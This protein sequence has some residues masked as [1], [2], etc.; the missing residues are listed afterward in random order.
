MI[1]CIGDSHASFFSGKDQMQPVW[2]E[3]N[4]GIY[5]QFQAYRLGAVLAYNL[6]KANST[7]GGRELLLAV[8]DTI[9]A[10]DTVM[11]CFGEID[12]RIHIPKRGGDPK[13]C[14]DRYASVVREVKERFRTLVWHAVP[15]TPVDG[16]DGA[17]G[18]CLER[19][20]ITR[21]FNDR[22]QD[23]CEDMDV[24]FVSIFNKLL[25]PDGTTDSKYF[26]DDLHLSQLAMPF[27][28][29]AVAWALR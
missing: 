15:S 27:A 10:Q 24:G 12:C 21:E 28:Q 25:H 7:S 6:C 3:G 8:L 9:P 5:P 19:N 11:L 13:P 22:M 23:H 18:T 1:H 17:V 4:R 16:K 20:A 2:P 14:A 29:E 26:M